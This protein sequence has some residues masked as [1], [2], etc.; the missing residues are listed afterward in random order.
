M[1]VLIRVYVMCIQLWRPR[2]K[3][4]RYIYLKCIIECFWV[5]LKCVSDASLG[6]PVMVHYLQQHVYFSTSSVHRIYMY[7]SRHGSSRS[8]DDS[9]LDTKIQYAQPG[10]TRD[11]VS[12]AGYV[13]DNSKYFRIR[14]SGSWGSFADP[15]RC[16]SVSWSYPGLVWSLRC[17]LVCRQ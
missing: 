13:Q 2:L 16:L 3:R 1:Y 5:Y 14:V 11:T 12:S 7:C 6:I 17:E 8:C 10:Y 4:P 9:V 15:I